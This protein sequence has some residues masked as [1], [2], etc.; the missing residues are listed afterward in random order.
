MR[1]FAGK[2]RSFVLLSILLISAVFI[3]LVVPLL[4]WVGNE[5][6]WTYRSFTTLRAL[7]LADAGAELAIW[8]I[9]YNGAGFAA[10]GGTNPKTMTV[11]NFTDSAG[12]VI[13]DIQISV[14][15]TSPN[16]Y[17]VTST[18]LANI[19]TASDV[20]KTVKAKVFPHRL[21]NNAIFGY[22]SVSLVGISLADSYDSSM[23]PYS[24]LTAGSNADVGSNEELTIQGSALVKGNV[25]IGPAG[26]IS[27]NDPSHVTGE[28][29]YSGVTTEKVVYPPQAYLDYLNGLPL[30]SDIS[31]ASN[32]LLTIPSGDFKYN[33]IAVKSSAH[34]TISAN[35]NI[36]V[37]E[38][39]SVSGGDAT[40]FTENGVNIYLGGNASFAGVGLVNP[41]GIPN[42]LH[43][44][45]VNGAT[46][47]NFSGQS[48]FYGSIYAPYAD[49]GLSG[50]ADFF[51][52]VV[53][54]DV[55]LSGN[56]KFHYDEFLSQNGPFSGYD[57]A[58]W[59]EN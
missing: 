49:I 33:K 7:N 35:S 5:F 48:N 56:F 28:T 50:G 47:L 2:D 32:D 3:I 17:L 31:L 52:A 24:S 36:Y 34:L 16:N 51:G 13:G 53:G 27:G 43:I 57:V 18:G 55:S 38:D 10:W 25:L 26:T 58:Y 45:G 20:S 9:L 8:E 19:N 41:S 14:L 39:F 42:N 22:D 40:V 54:D 6:S 46:T 37:V 4:G 44:Y 29:F 59:Q 21:F 12:K 11:S 23:G 15:T 30:Q 1:P